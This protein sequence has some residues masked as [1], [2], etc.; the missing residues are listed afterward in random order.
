MIRL[1]YLGLD[2]ST[3][4]YSDKDSSSAR[5]VHV[6]NQPNL[7]AP[8]FFAVVSNAVVSAYLLQLSSVLFQLHAQ[9]INKLYFDLHAYLCLSTRVRERKKRELIALPSTII[10]L[11]AQAVIRWF[12]S[13]CSICSKF[14]LSLCSAT[15]E[16]STATRV[17]K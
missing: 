11:L 8:Q 5:S 17:W 15:W 13:V 9:N 10:F 14:F 16:E 2:W 4:S 12:N 7:S 3:L 1:I 6:P